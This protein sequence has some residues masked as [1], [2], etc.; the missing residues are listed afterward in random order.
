MLASATPLF[1]RDVPLPMHFVPYVCLM[2][3]PRFFQTLAGLD[4]GSA[5]GGLGASRESAV[6]AMAEP[7]LLIALCGLALVA[8][9]GFPDGALG[10]LPRA[11]LLRRPEMILFSG[12]LF[13]VMLAE[14]SRIPVDD[15]ATHLEL[16]MIHEAMVLDHSG[17]DLGMIQLASAL[18]L[19]TF[20]ALVAGTLFFGSLSLPAALALPFAVL[21]T[22]LSGAAVGLVESATARLKL[23]RVASFLLFAAFLA[24][25]AL[26]LHFAAWEVPA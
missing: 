2:A 15:P 21:K 8:N 4:T 22:V 16:T 5:F 13:L 1:S 23:S 25:I 9:S 7:A 11:G 17:V 26:A 20:S 10:A 14:N 24:A 19:A 12:T 6:S 18:R 3:L